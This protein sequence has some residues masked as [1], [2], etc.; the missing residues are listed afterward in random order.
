[1]DERI[2]V[3]EGRLSHAGYHTIRFDQSI[4]V[5]KNRKFAVVV[6]LS[7][8]NEV[9][10]MAIEYAADELTRN[11][12]LEDGEGYVSAQGKNWADVKESSD[13]NLC[14]KAYTRR[15]SKR[16]HITNEETSEK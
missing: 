1:M 6:W 10:P 14:I 5:A 15:P 9:R 11:V 7:T 3:A 2:L 12:D 16:L 13:C 8:P 4:R